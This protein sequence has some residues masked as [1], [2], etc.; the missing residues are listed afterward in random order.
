MIVRVVLASAH[1]LLPGLASAQDTRAGEITDE[2]ADKATKLT[3]YETHWAE[4]MLLRVRRALVEQ[5]SGLYPYFG[6]VYN[7][8]GFTLGAGY[9]H[10]TGDRSH[11]N[12]DGLYSISAYKLIEGHF[13]SPGH[14]SGK[15]DFRVGGSWRDATQVQYHG[16]GIDSPA[17]INTAYRM[18][19]AIVGGDVTVRPQPWLHLN[20][21]VGFEDYTLKDPTGSYIPLDGT[22]TP[23]TA[24]GLGVD[25]QYVHSSASAAL[26]TR[27]AA[28]YARHGSLLRV[29]YHDYADRDST[30]SFT[31]LDA[32]AV[33]H[34]PIL[35]EN[36]VLSLH[37]R[38]ETILD[39]ADQ[40]PFFM[41][42]SLGN[43]STLRGYSSW[44]FRDRHGMLLQGEWRWIPSR[45]AIDMAFFYDTGMV[46][47][48]LDAITLG[49][50]VNDYGIGIR[51]HSIGVTPLRV[52]YARGDEGGRIVFAGSAAF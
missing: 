17:D 45:L 32:E 43:G 29:V 9:R 4:N 44:R 38:L 13:V 16:M 24:P 51:F 35:R 27:P 10:F 33:Q 7:G 48:R 47:P 15:L 41:L 31:R 5:P 46:A 21:G 36:W 14:A 22:F 3:P 8:G 52:E 34:I 23:E 11:F 18:Q 26:D 25:P 19:W 42:P 2:Q 20:G 1:V 37:G 50:F 6:S 30:Y 40:V 28:D 39:D 49:R 12:V